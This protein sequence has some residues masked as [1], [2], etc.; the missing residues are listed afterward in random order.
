MA[1][2][3]IVDDMVERI[4][5]SRPRAWGLRAR[6]LGGRQIEHDGLV[7]TLT[8]IP[9]PWL[10]PTSVVRDPRD[11]IA[12]I[13]DAEADL[14]S[15]AGGFGMDIVVD[16]FPAV[17]AAAEAVGL[18]RR[19]VQPLMVVSPTSIAAV[20]APDGIQLS[21]AEDRL[22]ELAVLDAVVFG[23]PPEISLAFVDAPVFADG[24]HRVYAAVLDGTIVGI[25]ATWCLDGV[26]S[27]NGVATA[28][29]ERRK[30]IGAALTAFAVRDRADQ[31]DLAFLESSEMA[32]GVYSRLGFEPVAAWEVWV[33]S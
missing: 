14:P 25:A 23:D 9:A 32:L 30:G 16:R 6:A 21:R 20:E 5:A 31:S 10:N 26:L 2:S 18:S 4:V 33:R 17:R 29:A 1:V 24:V 12:A 8:G 22:D 11:P 13:A 7:T 19:Q 27:V 15:D 3:N 28:Q